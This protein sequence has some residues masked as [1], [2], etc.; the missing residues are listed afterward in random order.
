MSQSR[1]YVVQEPIAKRHGRPARRFSLAPAE[2]YG[3]LRFVLD[4]SDTRG[5]GD[6]GGKVEREILWKIRRAMDDYTEDDYILMTGN[7]TAM[8]LAVAIA[9]EVTGGRV[10]CLQWDKDDGY[11]VVV[12]DI[13][14]PPPGL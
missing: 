6:S 7:W 13:N 14:A 12:I 5:L 9:L 1:V 2:A 8:A 11:K 10:R 4:W 3:E